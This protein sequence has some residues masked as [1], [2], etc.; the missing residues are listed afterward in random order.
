[1]QIDTVIFDLDGTLL[2]TLNDLAT[3]VNYALRTHGLPERTTLEIRSFLGN[4][5]RYL[6]EKAVGDKCS[7]YTFEKIFQ[8]F[9][10][11]YIQH[12]QDTTSPFEGII[13]LLSKLKERNIKMAI[14]SNKLHPAVQK[15]NE[16]FF[17]DFITTAIGESNTVRR[18]PAPDTIFSALHKLKSTRKK[19]IYIGD[20]EVDLAT[21]K[22][23]QIPCG[24][25]LWG[26][27]DE[28]FLRSLSGANYYLLQPKDL[29]EIVD[30]S[31][32]S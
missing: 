23:A 1:M 29:L 2:N 25:V 27:R 10:S 30:L 17:K 8:T 28:A 32:F 5:I 9:Q 21:A 6:M 31:K 18:K 3:S 14:V 22:N 26:F 24:I 4:G 7:S 19:A 13:P 20:S 15:L 16:R 11:Y 12:C